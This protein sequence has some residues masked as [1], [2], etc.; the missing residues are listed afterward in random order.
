MAFSLV[1]ESLWEVFILCCMCPSQTQINT[2][3]TLWILLKYKMPQM[4]NKL[5]WDIYFTLALFIHTKKWKRWSMSLTRVHNSKD[6]FFIF[7]VTGLSSNWCRVMS[8]RLFTEVKQWAMLVVG[9]VTVWGHYQCLL[10]LCS[11]LAVLYSV[12]QFPNVPES[13]WFCIWRAPNGHIFFVLHCVFFYTHPISPYT[14]GL[15]ALFNPSVCTSA[16]P[17]HK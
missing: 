1:H 13:V 7:F 17:T 6:H 11:F 2:Y 5:W 10:W 15:K 14:T 8:T 4:T 9:W 3:E 16:A 12:D